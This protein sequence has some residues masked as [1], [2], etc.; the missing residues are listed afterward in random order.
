MGLHLTSKI[1]GRR[2]EVEEQPYDYESVIPPK[3]AADSRL[4]MRRR[5]TAMTATI[6]VT[7]LMIMILGA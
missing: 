1:K 4:E 6:S 3:C 2:A 5:V 7:M